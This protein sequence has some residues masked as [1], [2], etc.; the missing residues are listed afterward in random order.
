MRVIAF[1]T[2][3]AVAVGCAEGEGLVSCPPTSLG[4][5]TVACCVPNGVGADCYVVD[6]GVCVPIPGTKNCYSNGDAGVGAVHVC[7]AGG[8]S[9][10]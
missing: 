6:G 1:I 5:G 9:C 3:L 4:G 8:A 10:G 2:V 7:G